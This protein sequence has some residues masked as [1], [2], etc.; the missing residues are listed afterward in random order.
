M[1]AYDLCGGIYDLVFDDDVAS[2]RQRFYPFGIGAVGLQ[3]FDFFV[4][5][6]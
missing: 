6:F 2:L 4:L 1:D 3:F 5:K